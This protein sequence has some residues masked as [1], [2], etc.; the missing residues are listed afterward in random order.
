VK[1]AERAW[2]D[3]K[4]KIMGQSAA[5]PTEIRLEEGGREVLAR[6]DDG[7]AFALPAE[8]LRVHSPSA[9]VRGHAPEEAKTIGGKRNVRIVD[10]LPVGNYAVR[11]VFDDGHDTGLYPWAY[12]IEL[13]RERERLFGEYLVALAAKGLDRDRPGEA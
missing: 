8:Y 3:G 10:I 11:F 7:A 12:L 9:E 6:F 5:W 4:A 2:R 13:G 1:P